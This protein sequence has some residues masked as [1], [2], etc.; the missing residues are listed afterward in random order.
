M[1]SDQFRLA[2]LANL[3]PIDA[4][5]GAA[6][7]SRCRALEALLDI[8]RHLPAKVFGDAVLPVPLSHYRLTVATPL[9]G[10]RRLAA[11]PPKAN[12]SN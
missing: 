9:I 8:G 2:V 6:E 1:T 7:S 12:Q 11:H 3:C 5:G 4:I 10:T